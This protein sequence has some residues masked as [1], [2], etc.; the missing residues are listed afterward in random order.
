M[1]TVYGLYY[2]NDARTEGFSFFVE[3]KWLAYH[4]VAQFLLYVT[5]WTIRMEEQTYELEEDSHDCG[6]DE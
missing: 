6:D 4:M 2:I 3:D 1:K 5:G